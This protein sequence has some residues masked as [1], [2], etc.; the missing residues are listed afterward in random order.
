VLGR[1]TDG[2]KG[3]AGKSSGLTAEFGRTGSFQG[4]RFRD[5]ASRPQ[6]NVD[7]TGAVLG[8]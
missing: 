3:A 6:G 5:P 2:G 4:A 7:L 1:V 8:T